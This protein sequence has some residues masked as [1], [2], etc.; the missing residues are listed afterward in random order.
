MDALHGFVTAL[1]VR[2][3]SARRS[4]S[5]APCRPCRRSSGPLSGAIAFDARQAQRHAAGIARA[6]LHVVERHLDH[7]L[8]PEVDDVA[9]GARRV[10]P[11][12][13]RVCHS[14][15]SSVIPL[16]VLPSITN[17]PVAGSRAPRW[18]LL[19]QPSRR[20][21]PHSAAS[22]TRSSVCAGFTLSQRAAA[23]AR[24][25]SGASSDFAITPSCPA[26]SAAS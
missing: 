18:M 4:R 7:D 26:A 8:R 12:T 21:L 1:I 22:T 17:S 6:L 15:I 2:R 20:P 16:K 10:A 3:A 9:L 19:S 14:R 13:S 11:G 5:R 25:R 23:A 24:P